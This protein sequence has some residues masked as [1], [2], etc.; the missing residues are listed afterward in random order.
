MVK[1][2]V[3]RPQGSRMSRARKVTTDRLSEVPSD[4][5]LFIVSSLTIREAVR[6][7][8][9]SRKWKGAWRYHSNLEF[10]KNMFADDPL[11]SASR[12]QREGIESLLEERTRGFINLVDTFLSRRHAATGVE[13][14]G[15]EFP[16][17]E[18]NARHVDRWIDYAISA[19][20][21]VL[22]LDFSVPDHVNF[23]EEDHLYLEAEDIEPYTVPCEL[24][25]GG[26]ASSLVWLYLSSCNLRA[27]PPN[28]DGFS[29]LR[30][31]VLTSVTMG[32][33]A[34]HDLLP[35]CSSLEC[36]E[37]H[38]CDWL[39]HLRIS[40]TPS[41]LTSLTVSSCHNAKSIV[42]S[43][44]SLSSIEYRGPKVEF[45]SEHSPKLLKATI[46]F[47]GSFEF[48]GDLGYI[49]NGLPHHLPHLQTLNLRFS[50][51]T[52]SKK[53]LL[54]SPNSTV[55]PKLKHLTVIAWTW[56]SGD[57]LWI[58]SLLNA[59]PCVETFQLDFMYDRGRQLRRPSD[60]GE[61]KCVER[62]RDIVSPPI[63]HYNGLKMVTLNGFTGYLNEVELAMCIVKNAVALQVFTVDP[64]Y[65]GGT[66]YLQ[67]EGEAIMGREEA[68]KLVVAQAPA[69]VRAKL[70]IN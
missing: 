41:R 61:S 30:G 18:E 28:F 26:R 33:P 13:R 69:N 11:D 6:A 55:F 12:V 46:A 47:S 23:E 49:L 20:T 22:K 56:W 60:V 57:L 14:F 7:D 16:L 59:A 15:V 8:L 48:G 65:V 35:R 67:P 50:S 31:L 64:C 21:K 5:R 32:E 2:R 42:I 25:A 19:G 58:V 70:L 44:T 27:P 51:E 9:I 62:V 45:D 40:S 34:F 10:N 37:I 1:S 54:Q 52:I 4:I 17:C 29:S 68:F 39:V 36:L 24:F 43:S 63:H 3:S 66:R 38:R 53:W